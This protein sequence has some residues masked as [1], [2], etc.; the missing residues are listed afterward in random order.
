M[1]PAVA[2]RIRIGTRGVHAENVSGVYYESAENVSGRFREESAANI[3]CSQCWSGGE[4]T[5]NEIQTRHDPPRRA[6]SCDCLN[7]ETEK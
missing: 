1:N 3:L 4:L 2:V 5:W 7:T 6:T